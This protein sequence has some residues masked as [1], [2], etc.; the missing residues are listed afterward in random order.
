VDAPASPDRHQPDAL[1]CQRAQDDA[2][3]A[4]LETA[5]ALGLYVILR[6]H[7]LAESRL[8]VVDGRVERR[9]GNHLAG[10]GVHAFTA[11]GAVGFASV[12]DLRPTAAVEAVRRAGALAVAARLAGARPTMSLFTLVSQGRVRVAD[13][14]AVASLSPAD[15]LCA[16]VAA[17][18]ALGVLAVGD[19]R[20]VRS[21]HHLVD[22]RWRIVR[23]DGADVSFGAPRAVLRH[24]L[25]GRLDGRPARAAASVSGPDHTATL[26]AAAVT[27]VARRVGR[28]AWAARVS[29]IPAPLPVG[30][31]RIVLGYALAKGLAH[32][33]IGHL[34]ESDVDGS[35][36]LRRGKLR[37]GDQLARDTVTVVDGPLPGQYVQQPY[38]ANGIPRQTV[39][40]VDGGVLAAGLGDLFSAEAAGVPMTGACRSASFRDRPTPRMTN[41]RIEVADAAPLPPTA[42]PDDLSPDDVIAALVRLGLL[43]AGTPTLY[44]TGYRGGQAHPR[45]GDFVFGAEAAFDLGAGGAPLGPVSFTGLAERALAAIVTGIGPLCTDA[46]GICGKDGSN[47]TSSGGS[48]A[49]LVLDP[50]PDLVVTPSA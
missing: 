41:I 34:C 18:E 12:D 27:R 45:R 31:P 10:L 39:R 35:V 16:V 4:A 11:D 28:A 17:Q 46:I 49:L 30:Q 48:H 44:L 47:V 36:L 21:L 20:T 40:L 2:V 7:T 3:A 8:T 38:S 43:D 23:S 15:E 14:L 25:G 33:A 9:R 32:E 42:D 13:G 29:A 37:L 6:L 22:E 50:D 5:R 1:L 24:D 26:S 19:G